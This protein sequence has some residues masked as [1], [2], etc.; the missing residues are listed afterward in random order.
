MERTSSLSRSA[1][2]SSGT[3]P[4]KGLLS[5]AAGRDSLAGLMQRAGSRVEI[6]GARGNSERRAEGGRW[7]M[8]NGTM[9]YEIFVSRDGAI[10][11]LARRR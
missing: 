2:S 7:G 5:L 11:P 10:Y 3:P 1:F 4:K 8:G 6:K 9:R